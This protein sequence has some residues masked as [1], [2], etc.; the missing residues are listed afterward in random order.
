MKC[1]YPRNVYTADGTPRIVGCGKCG[2]CRS[3]I[4]LMWQGRLYA[5][6]LCH[7]RVGAFLTL[8]YRDSALPPEY[9]S[10]AERLG[11]TDIDHW[12]KAMKRKRSR[13]GLDQLAYYKISE[14]G[15]LYHRP[16]HHVIIVGDPMHY[17]YDAKQ[18]QS[19]LINHPWKHGNINHRALDLKGIRYAT[20]YIKS[21]WKV[22]AIASSSH[23]I[24]K[25]YA[26]AQVDDWLTRY[27]PGQAF[28]LPA[29][30]SVPG[31]YPGIVRNFPRSRTVLDWQRQALRERG[32]YTVNISEFDQAQYPL[33]DAPKS[34]PWSPK[35]LDTTRQRERERGLVL[36]AMARGWSGGGFDV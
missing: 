2:W 30:M 19:C 17:E 6:W 26:I 23:G 28:L 9:G 20:Q 10:K 34:Y 14:F 7:G 31:D 27:E 32:V 29:L 12:I 5:E 1:A 21:D 8:T 25:T 15:G 3:Q 36:A 13:H 35:P 22:E 33:D 18:K 4:S 24:G 16:H 11:L